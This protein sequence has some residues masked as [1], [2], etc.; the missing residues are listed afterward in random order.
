ML[1]QYEAARDSANDEVDTALNNFGGIDELPDYMGVDMTLPL[2]PEARFSHLPT[3]DTV[4]AVAVNEGG[5]QPFD[6]SNLETTMMGDEIWSLP[7]MNNSQFWFDN[8]EV[9]DY[10]LFDVPHQSIEQEKLLTPALRLTANMQA[11]FEAKSRPPSPSLYEEGTKKW[12]SAPP[13]LQ[14]YPTDILVVFLRLF[15]R[16][17]P[18]TFTVFRYP[19]VT[20]RNHSVEYILAMAALGGLFSI[21]SG[22][23]VAKSMYNDARRL[24]LAAFSMNDG[25]ACSLDDK[26]E[27]VKTSL[28]LGLWGLCSGDKQSYEFVEAFQGHLTHALREF[29]AACTESE[30]TP[31]EDEQAAG[32]LECVHIF[33]CYRVII[34]MRPPSLMAHQLLTKLGP[35]WTEVTATRAQAYKLL[36]CRLPLT[37][38][39]ST[40]GSLAS[41]ATHLYPAMYARQNQYGDDNLLIDNLHHG[42]PESV[43]LACERW[44]QSCA[45][46]T[47]ST[48]YAGKSIYHMMQITLHTNITILQMFAHSAS[49]SFA[50][51]PATSTSAK[52]IFG[53]VKSYHYEI[54]SWHAEQ[55]TAEVER[56]F[57]TVKSDSGKTL[58]SANN[59]ADYFQS[60]FEAP[61][62]PFLIYYSTLILWCKNAAAPGKVPPAQLRAPIVRGERILSLHRVHV[63]TLLARVLAEIS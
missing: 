57:H 51:D 12:Y 17:I 3:P 9:F 19:L 25:T 35:S 26:L 31:D 62:V 53:W 2:D 24:H 55:L 5:D 21:V 58:Q 7:A 30:V 32:L 16:H 33:D 1:C 42:N 4:T 49:E 61:H 10:Q 23:E 46:N 48:S 60:D 40:L 6:I 44:L 29:A 36:D 18:R 52:E 28:L 22:K 45:H 38:K 27:T 11:Y 63:A 20:W 43:D 37:P 50:R 34:M 41:L 47:S 8:D 15:E 14:R 39:T 54:A 13:D 56:S 59:A